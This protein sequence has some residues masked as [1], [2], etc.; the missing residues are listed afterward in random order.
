MNER[1]LFF[2]HLAQT[3][4]A[5]LGLHIAKAEGLYLFDPEGKKYL[6][7]I[8]GISVCNLGHRHPKILEAIKT[9]ADQY[10]HVLVYGEFIQSPQV[11]YASLLA[12]L[13]PPSL[14][15]VY[16][17]NSGSEA[18]EAAMKLAK[19]ITNRTQIIAFR[20]SYHGSSQGALSIMGDEY[21]RN[22]F[23]PLLPG[24]LHLDYNSLED[25]E[26]IDENTACVI[27][28][29][30]QAERGVYAPSGSWI[31]ALER[32]CRQMGCLLVLDEIQVG[33]GRTGTLWAF[34]QYG[35]IPDILLLGKSL[36]GGLPLGALVADRELLKAF[37]FD[38]TLGH[39]TTFGGHPLCCAAGLAATQALISEGWIQGVG[40]K[41]Q[42]FCQLLKH[43]K[44]KAL[45]SKGLLIA[46]EFESFSEAKKIVDRSI[47][48]G[49]LTD[50]F[51]FAPQCLR[52]APP[53]TI[54]EDQI[55]EACQVILSSIEDGQPE[56]ER[57]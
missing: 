53:L 39:I 51:L 23:R 37:S 56:T 6:D 14:N 52:L 43:P 10:L 12:E 31:K 27:A 49:V 55:K 46:L 41:E 26:Q 45:R 54:S 36:G 18:V 35:V 4:D 1:E 20:W 7:L 16:F 19:R 25:L 44:I 29:T 8:G 30:V 9:Q 28:E 32:R 21:W 50:W 11:Q 42:L 5:P 3:S 48:K 15:C 13:L 57:R 34:E 2:R 17:T 40:Q 33:F 24:I 47:L 22:A 38:P